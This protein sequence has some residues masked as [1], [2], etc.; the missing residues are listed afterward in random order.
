[1]F[2]LLTWFIS[3]LCITWLIMN[4]YPFLVI[5]LGT[6][7]EVV[8]RRFIIFWYS[9]FILCLKQTQVI[10]NLP[11]FFWCYVNS[12]YFIFFF[13]TFCFTYR[14]NLTAIILF[15]IKSP[16]AS[17]VASPVASLVTTLLEAVF[18][19]SVVFLFQYSLLFYHIY[20][21]VFLKMMKSHSLQLNFYVLFQL[22]I[23]F[24]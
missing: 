6:I 10:N 16:A 7:S 24:L 9:I 19:V 11:S 1:M 17:A 4:T 23:W 21:Q 14:S 8:S 18:A 22:N 13:F 20:L 3:I 12:M 5:K 15:K 2:Y